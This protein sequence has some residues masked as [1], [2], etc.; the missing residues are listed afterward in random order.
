MAHLTQKLV[1]LWMPA[2]LYLDNR[3]YYARQG[4]KGLVVLNV[5][6]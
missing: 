1:L 3:N 4:K 5:L 6:Y 2:A